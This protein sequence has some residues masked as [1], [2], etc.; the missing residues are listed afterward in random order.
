ME[1]EHVEMN[2]D[3][4]H[5]VFSFFCAALLY[6]FLFCSSGTWKHPVLDVSI[7]Q[8]QTVPRGDAGKPAGSARFTGGT[9]IRASEPKLL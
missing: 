1:V 3:S 2:S 7:T 9:K 6:C 8:R 4:V 5:A